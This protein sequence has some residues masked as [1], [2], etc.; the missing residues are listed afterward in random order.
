MEW[1]TQDV[2]AMLAA[3]EAELENL[4]STDWWQQNFIALLNITMIDL[5]L[6][7]DNAIIVGLAAS[8]VAPEMRTKVIFWG[9]TAAVFLRIFFAAITIQLL[10]VIGLTLAG[11]LLLLFVCWKMYRQI[12]TG[13]DHTQAAATP[14]KPMGFW[15]AVGL[16][17]LADVSMSLDNVLAVAGAAKGSTLVL[18]IGLAVAII[19]MAV[20]SRMIAG[21]LVKHPWITWIGLFIILWVALDMIYDG[22]HEIACEA[23]NFGCSESLW[24]AIVHRLG[25]T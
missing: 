24:H 25:L 2:F 11:G 9:I 6:A 19:L 7:G 1:L 3:A 17:T 21:L 12:T 13:N 15:S 14:E 10:T 23:F 22:S 20:A 8:R 5:V 16:I 4:V 18:V